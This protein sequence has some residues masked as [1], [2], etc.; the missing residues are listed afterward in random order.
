MKNAIKHEPILSGAEKSKTISLITESFRK[1]ILPL[2]S[3]VTPA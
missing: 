1:K 3:S 2:L